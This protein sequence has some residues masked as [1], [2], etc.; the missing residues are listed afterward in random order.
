MLNKPKVTNKVTKSNE[1]I[2]ST[3][4]LTL[5]EHRIISSLI[6]LVQ[7]S[8]QHFQLYRF[9]VKDFAEMI[10]VKGD[11]YTYIKKIVT[12]LQEKTVSIPTEKS[13]L[14]VNWLA[15][16][17]YFDKEGEV[18]LEISNK[19]KPYLLE[20][21]ERFT[22]YHLQ[23]ILHLSSAHSVRIY[24]LLKQYQYI[25][26]KQREISLQ[27]LREWLGFVD[28]NAGKYKQYGHFK[29]KILKVAQKEL[30]EHTDISFEFEEIKEGR[31]V[32]GIRFFIKSN[33]SSQKD[34]N[35]ESQELIPKQGVPQNIHTTDDTFF[36]HINSI[37]SKRGYSFDRQAFNRCIEM[38]TQI[39]A[40]QAYKEL[41][42]AVVYVNANN[43]TENPVGLVIHLLQ[44]KYELAFKEGV[45][46]SM[47]VPSSHSRNIIPGWYNQQLDLFGDKTA[48]S[49]KEDKDY[50]SS[51]EA[52]ELLKDLQNL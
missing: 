26:T 50:P 37:T 2:E 24:E 1:L 16:A 30:S 52:A 33:K 36:N 44:T 15:S 3:Y 13:T 10:G 12:D 22:T 32:V 31:K 38:A 25:R 4:K 6:S 35:I 20:L 18:E 39:Y 23:H 42:K 43:K 40:D 21:K 48:E 8:D 17:E 45:V 7:P 27:T 19:L 41:E 29:N 5:Q 46:E 14:V 28:E 49:P 11:M 47:P 34:D 51:E 9:K